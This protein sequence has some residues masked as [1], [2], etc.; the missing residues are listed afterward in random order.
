MKKIEPSLLKNIFNEVLES[1]ELKKLIQIKSDSSKNLEEHFISISVTSDIQ[2]NVNDIYIDEKTEKN[3]I[4]ELDNYFF[5]RV[6]NF[7]HSKDKIIQKSDLESL[8]SDVYTVIC[9]HAAIIPASIPK[10]LDYNKNFSD[11]SLTITKGVDFFIDYDSIELVG[12]EGTA[13]S[14]PQIHCKFS[15]L[16]ESVL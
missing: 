15:F 4:A 5:N 11:S 13:E 3:L 6:T 2:Q 10:V 8:Q 7:I 9:G 16:L 12:I 1:S 14:S